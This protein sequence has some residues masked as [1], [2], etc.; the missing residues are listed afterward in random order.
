MYV[1][2]LLLLLLYLSFRVNNISMGLK[3]SFLFRLLK[4]NST[5]SH[6]NKHRVSCSHLP[7]NSL[8]IMLSTFSLKSCSLIVASFV[9]VVW[10][11]RIIFKYLCTYWIFVSFCFCAVAFYS[12]FVSC[13]CCCWFL[14]LIAILLILSSLTD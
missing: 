10:L 5:N 14:L 7:S 8:S 13:Y 2:L 11:S 1:L 6:N 4:L 9:F 3:L 12:R